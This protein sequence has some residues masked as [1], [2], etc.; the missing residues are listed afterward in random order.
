MCRIF[1]RAPSDGGPRSS[2]LRFFFSLSRFA[3]CSI[4]SSFVAPVPRHLV[5]SMA[6]DGTGVVVD[7][8]LGGLLGEGRGGSG[9]NDGNGAWADWQSPRSRSNA[10]TV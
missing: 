4:D 8:G 5:G 2:R 3:A 6:D 10:G 7:G 1:S 9:A